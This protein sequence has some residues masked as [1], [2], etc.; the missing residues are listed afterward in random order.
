V[1]F[2]ADATTGNACVVS[3]EPG[4]DTGERGKP[5]SLGKGS[6]QLVSLRRRDRWVPR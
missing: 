1:P 6:V 3:A 2:P 5:G 4:A